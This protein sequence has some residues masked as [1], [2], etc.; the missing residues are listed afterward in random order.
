ME[1]SRKAGIQIPT[2]LIRIC[3]VPQF[4]HC[5]QTRQDFVGKNKTWK[6]LYHSSAP[7]FFWR[8]LFPS[9]DATHIMQ[10]CIIQLILNSNVQVK[11]NYGYSISYKRVLRPVQ[12]QGMG[13]QMSSLKRVWP[14]HILERHVGQTYYCGHLWK[15]W[16]ATHGL[17]HKPN[18]EGQKLSIVCWYF[19]W[20]QFQ[21]LLR[22]MLLTV[23]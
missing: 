23:D 8:C 18:F 17:L 15:I 5:Y 19:L 3:A 7:S 9:R 13:N 14:V 10:D 4:L 12:I 21:F 6:L 11:W 20:N 16:S 2:L 1:R 22:Q